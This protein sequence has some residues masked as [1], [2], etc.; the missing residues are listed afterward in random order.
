M[1]IIKLM[2]PQSKF[3]EKRLGGIVEKEVSRENSSKVERRWNVEA[4]GKKAYQT[5]LKKYG[6]LVYGWPDNELNFLL[7]SIYFHIQFLNEALELDSQLIF[8]D[9]IEWAEE[10]YKS[11]KVS[12][13]IL[14]KSLECVYDAILELYG[15]QSYKKAKE[16]VEISLTHVKKT[17]IYQPLIDS[18]LQKYVRKYIE[19]LLNADRQ[20]AYELIE[21]LIKKGIDL[22]EIYLSLLAPALV[23]V[24]YMWQKG[25]ISV[26]QEHYFTASTQFI[27]T[28][29][30]A[31]IVK[32]K[33]KEQ[34]VGKSIVGACAP[35]ELHEIGL[36]MICDLLELDGYNTYFL[37]ASVP[38]KDL[39]EFLSQKNP[40]A[41]LLS[42]S[43]SYNISSL[44]IIIDQIRKDE[45]IKNV[46]IIVGG[47]PFK[48]DPTLWKRVGADYCTDNY[49]DLLEYLRKLY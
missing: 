26:A 4:I 24:G 23:Q 16:F 49:E 17:I 18:F 14:L 1:V 3:I 27:M 39:R 37:G 19:A 42:V 9:Y 31:E 30:F 43:M 28:R 6:Q 5:F 7:E 8:T 33:I 15:E 12:P 47:R 10:V 41:L 32:L 40:I 25:D 11:L 22:K 13:E 48:V 36:R 46:R 38:A 34:S 21:E 29:L 2:N 45:R 20:N 35:G 44:E